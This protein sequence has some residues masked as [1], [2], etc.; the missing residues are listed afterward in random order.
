MS[1]IFKNKKEYKAGGVY[2][3]KS[4]GKTFGLVFLCKQAGCYLIALSEQLVG[5][6]KTVTAEDILASPLYTVAWFSDVQLLPSYRLHYIGAVQIEGDYKNRAGMYE[7]ENGSIILKNC[8]QAQTWKHK[9][10]SFGLKDTTIRDILTTKYIPL[11]KPHHNP[12]FTTRTPKYIDPDAIETIDISDRCYII[13]FKKRNAYTYTVMKSYFDEYYDKYYWAP[14]TDVVW[15]GRYDT[16]EKAI[17]EA[18]EA[19]ARI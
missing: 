14:A 10:R 15:S 6:A 8:G 12:P 19:L 18:K 4:L 17:Q 11:S 16:K 2:R 13:I 7:Y 5:S 1:A 9:F 3:Y